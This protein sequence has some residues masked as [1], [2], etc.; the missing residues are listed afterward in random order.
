LSHIPTYEEAI[1]ILEKV[2]CSHLIIQHCVNVSHLAVKIAQKLQ[3]KGIDIDLAL[4]EIGSLLHDIGRSK[5]H[6]IQHAFLGAQILTSFNLPESFIKIVE[7]HIGSGIPSEEAV[8]LGLPNRDFIPHT[9]EEKIVSYSDKLIN[10]NR[11]MT[12]KEAFSRFSEDLGK[13]HPAITRFKKIHL[14]LMR[15][16]L[17]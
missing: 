2:G 10:G 3:A 12:F 9:L 4:V 8:K 17:A 14:E 16:L 5:T 7:R 11:E 15:I 6:N 13:S 1:S